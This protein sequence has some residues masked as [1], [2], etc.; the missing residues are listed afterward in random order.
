LSQKRRVQLQAPLA[1][2][3]PQPLPEQPLGVQVLVVLVVV[4]ADERPGHSPAARTAM[5]PKAKP[6][7][8][9]RT[10]KTTAI[11]KAEQRS[12]FNRRKTL[13]IISFL[14]LKRKPSK[15]EIGKLPS[16]LSVSG[17]ARHTIK[18]AWGLGGLN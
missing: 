16:L 13:I 11:A 7:N 17:S 10:H 6:A 14:R 2:L 12:T 5:A 15:L 8:T 18:I 3:N 9:M 4:A 1:R